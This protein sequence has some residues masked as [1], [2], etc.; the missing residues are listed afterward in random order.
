MFRVLNQL[1]HRLHH[2][3]RLVLKSLY[4][5]LHLVSPEAIEPIQKLKTE[6]LGSH[7]PRLHTDEILIAL[8]TSAASNPDAALALEQLS[9]L[10]GCDAHSSVMLSSVDENTF[11]KLGIHLTCEPKYESDNKKYHKH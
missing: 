11:K 2:Y 6:Y 7:N 9:K 10:K 3:V 8:S 1:L 5:K 4:H